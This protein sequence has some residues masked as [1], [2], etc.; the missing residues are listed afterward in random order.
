MIQKIQNVCNHKLK[1]Y[2][3][4]SPSF[5]LNG[6][7]ALERGIQSMVV[8]KVEKRINMEELLHQHDVKS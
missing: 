7:G 2:W 8:E 3:D 4:I 5:H 6:A 1:I